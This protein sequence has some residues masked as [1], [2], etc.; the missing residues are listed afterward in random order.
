[1]HKYTMRSKAHKSLCQD[2]IK[3][4]IL[5]QS[6]LVTAKLDKAEVDPMLRPSERGFQTECLHFETFVDMCFFANKPS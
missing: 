5:D 4:Y 3:A 6:A 2:F 1:V